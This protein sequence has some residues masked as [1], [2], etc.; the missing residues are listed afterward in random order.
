MQ[1]VSLCA[2][3]GLERSSGGTNHLSRRTALLG[4]LSSGF[5]A[6]MVLGAVA[7]AAAGAVA[8]S[9]PAEPA[10]A[11]IVSPAATEI[12][13]Q[14]EAPLIETE[15]VE[16]LPSNVL[17]ERV[18]A[19]V[20]SVQEWGECVSDAARE[21]SGEPFDPKEA[22][23]DMPAASEHGLDTIRGNSANAPGQQEQPP[24]KAADA[25]GQQEQPPGKAADAPGQQEQP[26]GKAADAPGQN[27]K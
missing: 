14:T 13:L 12:L 8:V 15:V 11:P 4:I 10:D 22:C 19:Y 7:V 27:R 25:P 17:L 21:H 2:R 9:R 16:T 23:D 1:G 20:E 6:K 18:S 26:P 5:L 24:G 3:C